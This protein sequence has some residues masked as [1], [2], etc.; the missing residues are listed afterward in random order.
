MS[1][2]GGTVKS[3]RETVI[4]VLALCGPTVPN[5]FSRA[6][7]ATST[8]LVPFYSAEK[9]A[10]ASMMPSDRAYEPWDEGGLS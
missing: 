2:T 5:A 1:L 8:G 10:H 6:T 4:A 3:H 7:A 9:P